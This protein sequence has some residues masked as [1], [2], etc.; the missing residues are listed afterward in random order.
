MMIQYDVYDERVVSVLAFIYQY[1]SYQVDM[2]YI[3][4]KAIR[5]IRSKEML[6]MQH[7]NGCGGIGGRG[8]EEKCHIGR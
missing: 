8:M 2:S 5:I 3:D 1:D 6:S 7:T 4:C